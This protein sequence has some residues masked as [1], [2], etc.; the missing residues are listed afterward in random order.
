MHTERSSSSGDANKCI[1]ERE[2]AI[3]DMNTTNN[4]YASYH[5][6]MNKACA[7]SARRLACVYMCYILCI[8]YG[9]LHTMWTIVEEERRSS[10]K[11]NVWATRM[12]EVKKGSTT[13]KYKCY[14][15]CY[16][17]EVRLIVLG[18][19]KTQNLYENAHTLAKRREAHEGKKQIAYTQ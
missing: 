16:V 6:Y 14:K 12:R 13:H 18:T 9:F 10:T 5:M 3:S 17:L 15:R 19:N 8:L 11:E 7:R 1:S 2:R 4:V